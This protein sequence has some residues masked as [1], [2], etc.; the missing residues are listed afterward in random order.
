MSEGPHPIATSSQTVGPFFHF[1]LTANES[2]GVSHL[3]TRQASASSC[4]S[5]SWTAPARPFRTR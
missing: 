4:G 2:S 5:V 3:L 1:G